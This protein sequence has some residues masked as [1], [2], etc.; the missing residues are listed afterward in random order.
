SNTVTIST[1]HQKVR[2]TAKAD[3]AIAD[4]LVSAVA[5]QVIQHIECDGP[6]GST[7]RV[8]FAYCVFDE[9]E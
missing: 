1:C 5:D 7:P 2:R 8:I 3:R 6:I 4:A 9:I